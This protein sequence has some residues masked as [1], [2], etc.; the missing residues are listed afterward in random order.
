MIVNTQNYIVEFVG[1]FMACLHT[2]SFSLLVGSLFARFRTAPFP[3]KI[4]FFCKIYYH[5]TFQNFTLSGSSIAPTLQFAWSLFWF[6]YWRHKM[7]NT[8]VGWLLEA[9]CSCQVLL[10]SISS[11]KWNSCFVARVKVKV[12]LR[13]TASQSVQAQYSRLCP[14][15]SSVCYNG[16]LVT[17]TVVCLLNGRML[18]RRQV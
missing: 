12:T 18:D 14:L 8:E 7:K 17:W 1:I 3:Q 11:F 13:L 5:I 2:G 15:F 16:S 4:L 9:R 10:K 6:Y